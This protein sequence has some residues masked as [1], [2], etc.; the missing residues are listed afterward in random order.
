[1]LA[2]VNICDEICDEFAHI[3]IDTQ[4]NHHDKALQINMMCIFLTLL[5]YYFII[6]SLYY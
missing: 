1:M 6:H 2:K 5:T 4:W 3:L